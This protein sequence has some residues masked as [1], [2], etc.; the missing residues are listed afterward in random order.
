MIDKSKFPIDDIVYQQGGIN[1][2]KVNGYVAIKKL[3][4]PK[5]TD[6][7]IKKWAEAINSLPTIP[8]LQLN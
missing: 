8:N 3:L 7:E 5:L 2:G 4:E 1:T 6:S